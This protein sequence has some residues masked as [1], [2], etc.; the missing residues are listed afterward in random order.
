MKTILVICTLFFAG[1]A[2]YFYDANTKI[3]SELARSE[4]ENQILNSSK[5]QEEETAPLKGAYGELAADLKNEIEQGGIKIIQ[6]SDRLSITMVNKILFPSGKAEI[7]PEGSM[8]LKRIGSV[9][10]NMPNEMIR[11]DGYTDTM[12]INNRPQKKY[13]TNWVLSTDR[14]TN[15]VLFL[16]EKVGVDAKFFESINTTENQPVADN[17]TPE[18]SS[19]NS[20]I[21]ITLLQAHTGE[22]PVISKQL[23]LE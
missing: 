10:K 22:I 13:S 18:D 1:L 7:T 5:E 9:L 17:E 20:M 3:H 2:Y 21:E 4:F 16:Q 11:V 6:S 15:V 12:Q 19:Q 14:A 8:V 23:S